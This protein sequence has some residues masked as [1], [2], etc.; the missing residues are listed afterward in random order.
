MPDVGHALKLERLTPDDRRISRHGAG[1][2]E[3]G[4]LGVHGQAMVRRIEEVVGAQDPGR[5]A[6]RQVQDADDS[7]TRRALSFAPVTGL[8]GAAGRRRP[9][10]AARL[11]EG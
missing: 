3:F 11:R 9:A 7:V 4:R 10:T 1:D 5:V 2:T 6:E 8:R